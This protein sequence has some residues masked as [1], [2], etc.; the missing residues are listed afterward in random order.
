MPQQVHGVKPG[1]GLE[2]PIEG[3]RGDREGTVNQAAEICRPIRSGESTPHSADGMDHRIEDDDEPVVQ[4][5]L[6]P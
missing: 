6:I 2:L 3:I 5:E 4:R 1:G